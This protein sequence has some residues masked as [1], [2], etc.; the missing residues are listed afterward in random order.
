MKRSFPTLLAVLALL[1]PPALGA[2]LQ[3]EP[4]A[5]TP[6]RFDEI[7]FRFVGPD[8]RPLPGAEV[9]CVLESTV[10]A[11]S[12]PGEPR[13]AP[14]DVVRALFERSGPV[15]DTDSDGV[16]RVQWPRQRGLLIAARHGERFG[17]A[18]M[19]H[20]WRESLGDRLAEQLPWTLS[21][22]EG[23]E[24]PVL[25]EDARGERVTDAGLR[26]RCDA[27][28]LGCGSSSLMVPP[29][30]RWS[31]VDPPVIGV[32][33]LLSPPI[34][35]MLD[36]SKRTQLT[37]LRLPPTGSVEIELRTAD[38]QPYL[39]G[40]L[41]TLSLVEAQ[42]PDMARR[43]EREP[44]VSVSEISREGR[45]RFDHVS[46]FREL[47]VSVSGRLQATARFAGPEQLGQNVKH[48]VFLD[49]LAIEPPAPPPG[50]P[51]E[52]FVE[53][54]LAG[55]LHLD[56]LVPHDQLAIVLSTSGPRARMQE[57][58]LQ[59]EGVFEFP[60][61]P[62]GPAKLE[63]YCRPMR[64]FPDDERPVLFRA[65]LVLASGENAPSELAGIDLRGKVFAHRLDFTGL[66]QT[67]GFTARVFF[68]PARRLGTMPLAR[69][70]YHRV[71]QLPCVIASPWPSIDAEVFAGSYRSLA[72]RDV[73]ARV[74][75]ALRPGLPVKLRLKTDGVL[76]EPPHYLKAVLM[77]VNQ[78][79]YGFDW[80][81]PA[82]DATGT[83]LTTAWDI[84]RMRVRWIAATYENDHLQGGGTLY[85]VAPQFVD[86]YESPLE[87]VIDVSLPAEELARMF[88]ERD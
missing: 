49:P 3:R 29:P 28:S 45:V 10:H 51:D 42:T 22:D 60:T 84:G 38:G 40:T 25:V 79:D 13:P 27:G 7:P 57:T 88:A 53:A 62:A 50:G 44:R 72:L 30:P 70:A 83:L 74:E 20:D 24:F 59:P 32:D 78:G 52:P 11:P 64:V 67:R 34:Q 65:D 54:S 48:T 75:V 87:Q 4:D 16:L 6:A 56:P 41:V 47:E 81:G 80:E 58:H 63:I 15:L 14:A 35:Q 26:V 66:D 68:S 77:P 23:D 31:G 21:L 69:R 8:Q 1:A 37:V 46:L 55:S 18:W 71:F 2:R 36:P 73:G 85:D 61:F 17:L 76:P 5:V 39:Q 86:V 12:L 19:P 82:F 9:R 33:E 43:F